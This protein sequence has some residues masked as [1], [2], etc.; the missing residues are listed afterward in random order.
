MTGHDI[1]MTLEKSSKVNRAQIVGL[2]YGT[3]DLADWFE[4][5]R[6]RERESEIMKQD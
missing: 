2:R 6:Q 5:F 4:F 1:P 3:S